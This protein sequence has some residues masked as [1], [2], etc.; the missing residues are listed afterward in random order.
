MDGF[1][2]DLQAV[3]FGGVGWD[4]YLPRGFGGWFRLRAR[5]R[6]CAG[7][8]HGSIRARWFPIFSLLFRSFL[9]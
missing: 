8:G 3:G 7:V 9:P 1:A 5:G 6:H 2:V 4:F